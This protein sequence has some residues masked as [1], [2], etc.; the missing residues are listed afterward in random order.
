MYEL[1][2]QVTS[3]LLPFPAVT[4][5]AVGEDEITQDSLLQGR[6]TV[7]RGGHAWLACGPHLEFV[8]ALTGERLS[9][10]RFS[11]E[12]EHPPSILTARDFRWLKRS[13]LLVGLEETEGSVLCLYDLGLS[14]VAKAVVIPG[15][16]TAIEPLVSY[17]GASTSTQHLHQSLRWFFGIAAVVTDLGHVL[18]VDLCLDDLS[19]NQSELKASGLQ[20]VTKTPKEIPKLREVSTREGRHLSLQ[21]N[22][23]SGVSAT[24][25]HYIPRTNQLA[26]GFSDGYLQLWNLK[27]LRKEYHS[28]LDGGRVPV[29]AFTFQEPEND[30]RNC[31]YLWAVQSSQ[32][33]STQYHLS[34]LSHPHREGDMV[35]LRLLQ[36][37]FSER[38]CLASGKILYEGLEYCEER[39]SQEL[40]GAA[41]PLRAQTINT[42][43]LCC[44]TI[45]KF[46][47]HPDRDDSMNEVASP[48]TSVAIF[49]WQV[50]AYG[51]G[52]PS[53][54]IGIFDINRW[55]HAQMPDSFRMGESLQNCP[56]LAIWCLNPVTQMASPHTL[57][58]V[59][60]QDHSLSRGLP[61]TFPPPEQYFN[62][63]AYNFDATCLFN[64]GIVHSNCSGY[65]KE[66]LSFLKKAAPC[67]RDLIS[68]SYS[69]CLMSGLLSS[70]LV[71]AHTSSISQEE[72]LDAILSTALETNSLG[73]ITGCIKQWT[74]EEQPGSAL[75]LRY[76]LDWAWNKVTQ[77]KE[78]LDG[79]CAPLF[80]TSSNFTD[81]QT[82]QLL[83]HSQ[84]LLENLRT[85]FHCL[86]TEAQ[87]LTQNGLLGLI[88]KNV[89]SSLI[90]K[91]AQVVLW[92]CRTGLLPE[93]SDVDA[94]QIP[95]PFYSHSVISNYYSIR[96]EDLTTLAKGKWC[97]DC[98]MI[99]SLVSQCGEQLT[100][101]WK[102][103]EGGTGQYPPP[104]LHALLDIY[105]LDS[106]DGA[107][108]HAI[109]IYLLLDVMY[110]F[111]SKEGASVESFPTAF[112]IPVGLV[113]L[114]QGLWLLDHRD[115]QGSFELLLN[116]SASQC[117]FDWQ[118]ERILQALMCQ[119]QHSLALRYFYVTKPPISSISQ[120][121]LCLAVL[122]HNRCLTEAWS[123]LRQ[124]SS[125]LNVAEL[126]SFLY[127]SCQELGLI[128]ELLKLPLGPT[129][130]ETLEKFLHS[131]GGV[132]NRE[133]LLVHYLQQANYI[134]ALRLNHSL[135]MHLVNER[136]PT[137]KERSNTRNSILDQYAKV[138][139]R[140]Q[141][142]L[143]MEKAK[144]YQHPSTIRK[145]VTRPQP[146]STISKRSANGKVISRAGFINNVLTK[147]EELWLAEGET[148]QSSPDRKTPGFLSPP[149]K[150]TSQT[151]AEPFLG[152]PISMSSKRKSRLIDMVVHP[153]CHTPRPLL[154]PAR[155]SWAILKSTTKAPEFNLLQTPLI[156][157]RARALA[158]SSR[159]FSAF[160]P[161]SI[162]RS[163]QRPTPMAT[164]SAS[165]RKSI[166][167]PLRSKES[168]I[169]FSEVAESPEPEN[170]IHWTNGMAANS[171]ISLLTRGA[172]LSHT[173]KTWSVQMDEDEEADPPHAKFMPPEGG[174]PSPQLRCSLRESF[175]IHE[176][177]ESTKPSEAPQAQLS[178][179][180]DTSQSFRS[181]DTTLEYY[182]AAL[183]GDH[184]EEGEHINT[185]KGD[186][187][188][189]VNL[190]FSSESEKLESEQNSIPPTPLQ[191]ANDAQ[192]EDQELKNEETFEDVM[193]IAVEQEQYNKEEAECKMENEVDTESGSKQEDPEGFEKEEP[194]CHGG[195]LVDTA[196]ETESQSL[197]TEENTTQSEFLES[198]ATLEHLKACGDSQAITI[199]QHVTACE[200]GEVTKFT[201]RMN[202]FG[203]TETTIFTEPAKT[204]GDSQ[205]GDVP[206]ENL[207]QSTDLTEFV[208]RHLFGSGLS[209]PLT[210]SGIHVLSQTPPSGAV[211]EEEQA[212]AEAPPMFTSQNS[213]PSVTSSEP[214][215]TDSH[216]VV[217][218]NES[219]EL[220]S[221]DDE[222]E[223]EEE[224]DEEAA[225]EEE[226]E[227]EESDEAEEECNEEEDDSGSEV[228]IIEE[229]QG[230]GSLRAL[231]P[232]S[233]FIHDEHNH[234]LPMLSEQEAAEFSLIPPGVEMKVVGEEMEGEVLMVRLGADTEAIEALEGEGPRSSYMELKPSTTLLVP[235]ELVDGQQEVID[236]SPLQLPEIQQP[237]VPD[238]QR[239][240]T[241]G[242]FSLMLDMDED[243]AKEVA[244]MPVE[245][246]L[247]SS[248]PIVV[249]TDDLA[250]QPDIILLAPDAIEFEEAIQEDERKEMEP[251]DGI[252]IDGQTDLQYNYTE[253]EL[254]VEDAQEQIDSKDLEPAILP[255]SE[256][257]SVEEPAEVLEDGEGKNYVLAQDANEE[258]MEQEEGKPKFTE[259]QK[260]Y[261]DNEPAKMEGT[262]TH[263]EPTSSLE[264]EQQH[265]DPTEL[266][267]KEE[268]PSE[269]KTIS[270]A[271][272]NDFTSTTEP[273]DVPE[274]STSQKTVQFT[275]TRMTTRAR[276]TVTFIS[277]LPVELPS[278][279]PRNKETKVR[280]STPRR[281]SRRAPPELSQMQE[282]SSKKQDIVDDATAAFHTSSVASP[283]RQQASRRATPV[284]TRQTSGSKDKSDAGEEEPEDVTN[285]NIAPEVATRISILDK[286]RSSQ[287]STPRRSSRRIH[288]SDE[289]LQTTLEVIREENKEHKVFS[290]AVKHSTR[291][292]RLK[293]S[294]EEEDNTQPKSSPSR[295]TR[296]SRRI[297]LNVNPQSAT[298]MEAS[299]SD[300]VDELAPS[301][302]TAYRR[303]TARGKLWDHPE[304]DLF[305]LHTPLEA[306]S[307]A[308]VADALIKR[309]Q[310]EEEKPKVGVVRKM[311]KTRRTPSVDVLVVDPAEDETSPGEHLFLHLPSRRRTRVSAASRAVSP[312]PGEDVP[313][314]VTCS[315]RSVKSASK[316]EF[317]SEADYVE[318]DKAASKIRKTAKR[319]AKSALEPLPAVE[320]DLISPLSSPANQAPQAQKRIKEAG[321]QRLSIMNLRRKRIMDSVFTKPITRRK[322][323]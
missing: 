279:T 266:D 257:T 172:S 95:R 72:Q 34:L 105:L 306:D 201:Q 241:H 48:D 17:G 250:T 294:K 138:L 84:R 234:F 100:N 240:E 162:L 184:R 245:D 9:A 6:F 215:G 192:H 62:P 142:K 61:L 205:P 147:I 131:A 123:L 150:P 134:P 60:V 109:V 312:G 103:D 130:Q 25:L 185:E 302:N 37:A 140:V 3:S 40:S 286:R 258:E 47:P 30:P 64:S 244:M 274:T 233:A 268:R 301:S 10:Y 83:Q 300:A 24:A 249:P 261:E 13:G 152:T 197:I 252:Q 156:V 247:Q 67:S 27:S 65:Q 94:M 196:P 307:E 176:A 98:L 239:C 51:Q 112:D 317:T 178:L 42:R 133:I 159:V 154:S 125:H 63:T 235:L 221:S 15:R 19:C 166:T 45:E 165:P 246:Y 41:F 284:R 104:T 310:D 31:C 263:P 265:L 183:P 290:P 260:D 14:R 43:L 191:I 203:D 193:E 22:G 188:V 58:D 219:E 226:E 173:R 204:C 195:E 295:A 227:E 26:V 59:V 305:L 283:S 194:S 79:I 23:P 174:I 57:L 124:H 208:E 282:E 149:L 289:L 267:S 313:G 228:E 137:L 175:S 163:S 80:D 121:R 89:V 236:S 96:R 319:K 122:L 126:H 242:T 7:G 87:E 54:Y 153:S 207:E 118:H 220:S 36:M 145:E 262:V 128:K 322:K 180:F 141:R 311:L 148:P 99:D 119:G 238:E 144:T 217:S 146:L 237:V 39:Y 136:D 75:N 157:K 230:N 139:P 309:L 90:S 198:T 12:G 316:E 280:A 46:R 186:G 270:E 320:A 199:T 2:A 171:E 202:A 321:S 88:N 114:V 155:P 77:T 222:E 315:K 135:K 218:V 76:I 49:S 5:E 35:S 81:P 151:Q 299:I 117:H 101:L 275:P 179:S 68:S 108:K 293:P 308:P 132:Q 255:D 97:A 224:E 66:T 231:P 91:Y 264:E 16:I 129:E 181:T 210:R 85:I 4:L 200:D 213:T 74:A 277:P 127:E 206:P 69:R 243:G 50:K 182:D 254:K 187:V 251:V 116:P 70:R 38:K 78:E 107:A 216:S 190:K 52:T 292:T 115:Y 111:P 211:E 225:A 167:P 93:G 92:F 304:E 56:Y 285:A 253:A 214:T 53:T 55:Y 223:D 102:R 297:T 229:I 73:L 18:L 1:T 168:R 120:A 71:D 296:Q 189:T 161:Q 288:N 143:A 273:E 82:M 158:A 276:R 248:E 170:D 33:Q 21:L 272:Q 281:S 164:P 232:D 287:T 29:H 28:Q 212:S 20:V 303:R 169:T 271:V 160:T 86:L 8:H 11:S 259:A 177:A 44:Q 256:S 298:K 278:R 318:E 113:K 209:P 32:D 323:L 269:T 314:A 291:K 110:S 106:V